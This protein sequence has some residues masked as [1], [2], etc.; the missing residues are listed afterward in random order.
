MEHFTKC[1]KFLLL[2][3]CIV[4]GVGSAWADEESIVFSDKGYAN[5]AEMTDVDATNFSLTFN[6]GTNSNNAPKYYTT[7]TAVRAYGGNTM[8]VTSDNVITKIVLG[9]G[10][11]DGSNAITTNVVTYKDGTWTGSANTVVF[12]IG[13][14]SGNRRIA[15]VTVTYET[16]GGGDTPTAKNLSSI[17]LSGEYPTVFTEGDAFSYEGMTVTAF[18]DDETDANVTAK[19]TFTG[20][21]MSTLDEQQTV[22]VSYTENGVIKTASYD[23]TVNAI[24][25]HTVTWSVNGATTSDT[26][27]EGATITF[28]STPANQESKV[29]RGWVTAAI[30]GTTDEAPEFV[31]SATMGNADI[32][33]YAVFA[34][35]TPGTQKTVTDVLDRATTGVTSTSYA[36]WSDKTVTSSSAVYAGNSAGGNS[37]I[38]FNNSKQ[39]GLISTTSADVIPIFISL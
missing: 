11:S 22:T 2:A 8:T 25:S 33:Y 17:E 12:T 13:G 6:K 15:S 9:F 20:Y 30:N 16:S 32:T 23:I 27:K 14:S 3:L 7:G 1:L 37:S 26:F 19:A 24:P 36:D 4:G 29:F 5:A 21:N 10:S 35:V 18:Y 39:S 38:Q 31:T 28:P 34:S